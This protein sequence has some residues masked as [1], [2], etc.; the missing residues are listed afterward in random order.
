MKASDLREKSVEDLMDLRKALTGEAFQNRLKNFTNRLDDTSSIRK[1]RRDLARLIT[2]LHERTRDA[3]AGN[4]S[5]SPS[6]VGS[7][8]KPAV[9]IAAEAAAPVEATASPATKA[10]K[11]PTRLSEGATKDPVAKS[12]A[13]DPVA[14]KKSS[15]KR[16]A[17]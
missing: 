8:V 12:A 10:K 2:V 15:P 14:K 7:A 16:E 4:P 9:A 3:A 11:R 17:K 6:P 13:K 5:K 1:S